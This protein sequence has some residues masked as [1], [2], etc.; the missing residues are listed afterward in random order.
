MLDYV[1][2]PQKLSQGQ[3]ISTRVGEPTKPTDG[4]SRFYI[5]DTKL[6]CFDITTR[7]LGE[8]S[9]YHD[10]MIKVSNTNDGNE[11]DIIVCTL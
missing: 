6:G 1:L 4:V 3:L 5:H 10:E 2:P 7:N 9:C 11:D 8:F